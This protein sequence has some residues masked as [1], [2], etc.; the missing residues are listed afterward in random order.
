M[1]PKIIS[2]VG[3]TT[4]GKSDLA[5]E[6][7]KLFNGEV[8]SC[9]SRQV[10]V[11]LDIGSAKITT[12]EMQGVPHHLLSFVEPPKKQGEN[13]PTTPTYSVAEFQRDAYRVIDEILLR[14]KLPILC[15]GTGLY[16]RAVVEGYNFAMSPA[17]NELAN[18]DN[19]EKTYRVSEPRYNVLQFA[20]LPPKEW[21]APRV[22]ARIKKHLNEGI[23]E[24]TASLL[25]NGVSP[26][27]LL[28][29]GLEY[30]WNVKFIR[31]EVTRDEYIENLY[32][33]TMQYAKRQRTWFKREKNTVFLTN[34]ETFKDEIIEKTK[35]FI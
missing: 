5:V 14:G 30:Y 27:F 32:T 24:E 6:I 28:K 8:V 25:K 33:R 34:P 10:Y 26:E 4:S 29:L 15:G 12:T 20:L 18:D 17:E 16:S 2:I 21:I 35:N 22:L 11:G 3:I 7:A 13:Q 9:D 1:K 31:G 19:P 23:I